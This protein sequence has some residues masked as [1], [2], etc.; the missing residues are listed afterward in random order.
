V[1][2]NSV[3]FRVTDGYAVYEAWHPLD[4]ADDLHDF[5]LRAGQTVG[6]SFYVQSWTSSNDLTKTVMLPCRTVYRAA[7]Y[8]S[9]SL[10]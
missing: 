9:P 1:D 4:S 2:C 10:N 6:F 5:S 8:L 3:A 7:S